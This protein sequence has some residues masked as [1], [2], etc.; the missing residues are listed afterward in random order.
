MKFLPR[1][2]L[3]FSLLP[4]VM[5]AQATPPTPTVQQAAPGQAITLSVTASGSA[6]FTYQWYKNGVA[7]AG[8]TGA[9]L[10]ISSAT[11]ADAGIYYVTVANSAG[12]TL[13]NAAAVVIP[14]PLPAFTGPTPPGS[15]VTNTSAK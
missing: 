8:F 2:T 4:V 6:P 13:S 15:A 7:L 14:P 1:F 10:A 11:P 9:S 5:W 12:I 3:W